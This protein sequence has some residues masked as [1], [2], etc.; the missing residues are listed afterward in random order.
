MPKVGNNNEPLLERAMFGYDGNLWKPL[1]LDASG[2]LEVTLVDTEVI[3]VIQDTY[4]DLLAT[5]KIA[6]SQSIEVT[7]DTATDLKTEVVSPNGDKII[8]FE[9]IVKAQKLNISLA[10][11]TNDEIVDTVPTGKVWCITAAGIRYTGT[12]PSTLELYAAYTGV[13]VRIVSVS[14]PVSLQY[15]LNAIPVWLGDGDSIRMRVTGA[16]LNDD[17]VAEMSGFQFNEP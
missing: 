13:N 12:V 5:V 7:Q 16:T 17:L 4:A 11:G 8:S 14:S 3:E 15:Y 2:Y 9:Q 1:T 10:A 6:A